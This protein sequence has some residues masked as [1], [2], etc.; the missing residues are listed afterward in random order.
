M[1]GRG[2][3]TIAQRRALWRI[4]KKAQRTGARTLRNY[5]AAQQVPGMLTRIGLK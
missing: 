5:A 3:R 1:R 2:W 4:L